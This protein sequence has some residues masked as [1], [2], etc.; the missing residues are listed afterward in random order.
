MNKK[1]SVFLDRD[2]VLN[3]SFGFRPPNN[4]SELQILPG[5]PQAVAKLSQ[6]GF[7][8]F[9]VTNQGGV[10]LGYMT[11]ENLA[12]IHE[13]LTQEVEKAGGTFTEIMACIH[14]PRAGCACRKPKPG[15]LLDLAH[16]YNVDL[17][18]SFMIGDRDMDIQAGQAAGTTTILI[19]SNE[20]TEQTADYTCPNLLAASEL[21]LGLS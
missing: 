3:K 13:K 7:L 17:R 4:A 15:M 2:G 18:K 8:V 20:K 16:K 10:G 9:V 12:S 19:K 5:A 11:S 1:K 21:I 6:A 14:K